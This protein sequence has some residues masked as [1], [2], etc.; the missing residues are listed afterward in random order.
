VQKEKNNMSK[1]NQYYQ[2]SPD[3]SKN[4]LTIGAVLG[5]GFGVYKLVQWQ[6]NKKESKQAEAVATLEVSKSSPAIVGVI[7][8]P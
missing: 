7:N 5:V 4:V 8:E 6:K 2:Q 1:F 3:L